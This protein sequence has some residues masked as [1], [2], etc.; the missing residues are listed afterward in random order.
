MPGAERGGGLRRVLGRCLQRRWPR[1]AAL[2][3]VL[4]VAGGH[5]AA[6]WSLSWAQQSWRYAEPTRFGLPFSDDRGQLQGPALGWRSTPSE[7]SAT[8]WSVSA[9]RLDGRLDYRGQASLPFPLPV[10]SHA[11][12]AVSELDIG[13]SRPWPTAWPLR[14]GLALNLQ[15]RDRTIQPTAMTVALREITDGASLAARLGWQH[16][17]PLS[18]TALR[19]RAALDGGLQWPLYQ[20]LCADSAQALDRVCLPLQAHAQ[21]AWQA[22]WGVDWRGVG[23]QLHWGHAT[24]RIGASRQSQTARYQGAAI[25]TVSYPGASLSVKTWGLSI[26]LPL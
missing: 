4:A 5:A 14:L 6:Q 2:G 11:D 25:G 18:G 13:A 10:F 21:Y 8:V 15:R 9:Q 1:G 16:D 3:L 24:Q 22:R 20:R 23:L 12:W 19:L 17:W 26:T 7:P